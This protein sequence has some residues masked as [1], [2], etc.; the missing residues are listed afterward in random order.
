MRRVSDQIVFKSK[1]FYRIESKAS[2]FQGF[3]RTGIYYT[4]N[5]KRFVGNAPSMIKQR[6]STTVSYMIPFTEV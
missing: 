3:F 4:F 6:F 2:L 5:D 1:R